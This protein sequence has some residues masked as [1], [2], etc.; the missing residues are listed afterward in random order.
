MVN[1]RPKTPLLRTDGERGF[2]FYDSGKSAKKYEVKSG[3]DW[4]ARKLIEKNQGSAGCGRI[5]RGYNP[6]A[7]DLDLSNV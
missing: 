5:F 7:P 3:N 6:I 4:S 2:V 1:R